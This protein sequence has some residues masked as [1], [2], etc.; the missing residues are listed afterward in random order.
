[1]KRFFSYSGLLVLAVL[2]I[3]VNVL[4][5]AVVRGANVDLTANKLY[6]LSDGTKNILGNL[7]EPVRLRF[8]FSKSLANKAAGISDFANRVRNLLTAYV[9]HSKGNLQL[10]VEDPE[11]FSETED[12]AVAAGLKGVPATAAGDM[13]YFGL[14]GTSTTDQVETIPFFQENREEFLEYDITKLVYNLSHP[15]KKVLA[16]LTALPI[17]GNPMARFTG[18][19]ASDP[20][21]ITEA[22]RESFDVRIL[23]ATTEKLEPDVDVLMVVHPQKLAPRVQFAIDQYVL[24][25]GKVLAFADPYCETMNVP[26]NPQNPLDAMMADRSSSLTPLLEAWGLE[27]PMED[28]AADKD[29]ALRVQGQGGKPVDFVLFL[30]L[31]ADKDVFSKDDSTTSEL[32]NVVMTTSG[33]LRKK[34]GASTTVSSLIHTTKSS[35]HVAKTRIQFGPNPAEL[36]ESFQSSGETQMLAARVNGPAK[37]AFPEGRP[38]AEGAEETPD[39]TPLVPLSESKGPINVIVVA[40][41]DMLDDSRWVRVQNFFG[42][43]MAVPTSDNAKFVLNCVENLSGSNDLISL[44]SRGRYTRPFDKVVE[45]RR[46]VEAKFSQKEKDLQAK[47]KDAET[48]ISELQANKDGADALILS[49]EAQKEIERFRDD[50]DRTRKELRSVKYELGKDIDALKQKL[51]AL[52]VGLVPLLVGLAGMWV[53]RRRAAKMR[54]ARENRSGG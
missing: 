34:E 5:G 9:A 50:R 17:D 3:A 28:L 13:F 4:S 20:W 54:E 52:N 25:G 32:E 7:E 12:A 49:P 8:Y 22:L 19:E 40:D 46:E 15:K 24:G 43:K 26:Q 6:T 23:P 38:K 45:L 51:V 16:I 47:L 39:A 37:T 18:G 27:M 29:L 30:G 41:V 21:F 33:F 10:T 48:K 42:Q 31:R 35:M 44:R 11:P 14:V 36:L 1:M 53:W 2:F